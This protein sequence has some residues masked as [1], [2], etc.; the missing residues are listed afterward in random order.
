MGLAPASER[1]SST[2]VSLYDPKKLQVRADVRL[3]DVAQV[4]LRQPVQ[5]STAALKEPLTGE[6]IMVTSQADIQK[7][8]LQ[9]KVLI[10][11]PPPVIKPEML[12]QVVFLAP[13][14]PGDKSEEQED[15]LRLLVPK[16]LVNK[17]EAGGDVWVADLQHKVAQRR[18]VELGQAGTDQLVEI[19]SGLT[20]L[21]KLIA[22]GR[23]S[24]EDGQRI[25]VLGIDSNFGRGP[26][27]VAQQNAT[28]ATTQQTR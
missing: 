1:D 10:H 24:L 22:V 17:T 18:S 23:E 16:E 6:V 11:D 21:D 15:P 27:A 2:V 25:K 9:V 19:T 5:V 3:E 12:V 7:N 8:T 14:S 26:T 4:S 13:Q 20:A 28:P